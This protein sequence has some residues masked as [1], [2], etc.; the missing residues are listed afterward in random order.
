MTPAQISNL[1]KIALEYLAKANE[2]KSEPDIELAPDVQAKAA[3]INKLLAAHFGEGQRKAIAHVLA[4]VIDVPVKALY[5]EKPI[6]IPGVFEDGEWHK[7]VAI[8]PLTNENSHHYRI[9]HVAFAAGEN[10]RL[11]CPNIRG[12]KN[13]MDRDRSAWRLATEEEIK[14]TCAEMM[15]KAAGS[16]IGF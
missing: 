10:H 2:P 12:L 3:R 6:D 11:F 16:D 14:A 5:T 15:A 8:V 13:H 7:G 1:E 4:A 9:G